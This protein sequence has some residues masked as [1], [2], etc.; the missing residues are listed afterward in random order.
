MPVNPYHLS[1]PE[2]FCPPE[3]RSW[4]LWKVKRGL[5][6]CRRLCVFH[7]LRHDGDLTV[8]IPWLL[9]AG[10]FVQ[11]LSIGNL[12]V[13]LERICLFSFAL[14]SSSAYTLGLSEL[15]SKLKSIS[16]TKGLSEASFLFSVSSL[17]PLTRAFSF[18]GLFFFGS[19]SSPVTG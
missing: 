10:K 13:F 9:W 1:V 3:T 12:N 4:R 17:P 16:S 18:L 6:K 8:G 15:L 7:V 11:F 5:I 14:K 19:H 2:T